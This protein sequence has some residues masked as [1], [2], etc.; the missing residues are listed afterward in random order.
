MN[1]R[2]TEW[3]RSTRETA[4]TLTLA[5]DGTGTGEIRTGIGFLDH[6]LA[7]LVCQARFDLILEARGDLAVDDHHTAEDCGLA[8]GQALDLCLGNRSGMARFGAAYAPMD[9]A[10]ARAV[11]DFSGRPYAAVELGLTRERLG[12]LSAENAAHLLASLAV[13]ARATLHVDLLR[14]ANDHH[15]AEAAFKAVGLALRAAVAPDRDGVPS[16]KGVL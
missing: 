13:T 1:E 15:R 3:A 12:D 8:L 11:V 7:A 2:K 6:L 5:L 14:G 10:L 16:T 4:I 9:E